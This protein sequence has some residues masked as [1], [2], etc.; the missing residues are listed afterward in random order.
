M[1]AIEEVKSL[2]GETLQIADKVAGF[3]RSTPLLGHIAELD[4]MAVITLITSI[5]THF[6]VTIDDDEISADTFETVGTLTDFV[7]AKLGS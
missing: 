2:I 1:S 3:T 6:G 7:D 4:S 5:E